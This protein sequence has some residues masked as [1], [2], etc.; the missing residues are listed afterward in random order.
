MRWNG[1]VSVSSLTR[2][3]LAGDPTQLEFVLIS[4]PEFKLSYITIDF[5]S[6]A[7][8]ISFVALLETLIS[9]K[10][11]D[12]MT[13]TTFN[14]RKEVFGL[15]LANIVTGIVGGIPA[16]AALAR[17]AL[18]INTGTSTSPTLPSTTPPQRTVADNQ[19]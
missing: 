7:L 12:T 6:S 19:R 13:K 2:H 9:A 5:F 4:W 17:T 11:A 10:I 8:S 14:Q 16:T 1:T 3:A 15:G 18:N